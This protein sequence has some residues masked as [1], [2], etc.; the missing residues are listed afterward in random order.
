LQ[1]GGLKY[2]WLVGIALGYISGLLDGFYRR[3]E[4]DGLM[5]PLKKM[6][7]QNRERYKK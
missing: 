5:Y 4:L 6:L 1:E 7:K 3:G 2:I